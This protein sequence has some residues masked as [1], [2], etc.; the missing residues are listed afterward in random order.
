MKTL[1]LGTA[2]RTIDLG[3][4][5]SQFNAALEALGLDQSS[6]ATVLGIGRRSI[7]RY[8]NGDAEV[9]DVVAKLIFLLKK[10]GI[11]KEFK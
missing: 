5:K 3:M 8:A 10:R 7:I 6:A 9:P 1:K 2:M 4:T 11:P